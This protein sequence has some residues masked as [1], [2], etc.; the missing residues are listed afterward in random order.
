MVLP[1]VRLAGAA[2]V[3][4][5]AA[6]RV[7]LR[8]GGVLRAVA[9]VGAGAGVA[10]GSLRLRPAVR[11]GSV[12]WAVVGTACS[13]ARAAVLRAGARAAADSTASE[14]AGCGVR[15]GWAVTS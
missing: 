12:A 5:A 14:A 10:A 6:V 3:V 7:V 11:A 8:P 4:G 9:G 15:P 1:L 13:A 2:A